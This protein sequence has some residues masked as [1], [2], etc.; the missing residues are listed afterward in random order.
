MLTWKDLTHSAVMKCLVNDGDAR[1]GDRSVRMA[2]C[3]EG[4][5]D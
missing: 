1:A 4:A 5:W 3:E 2:E